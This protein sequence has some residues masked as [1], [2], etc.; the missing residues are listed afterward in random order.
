MILH[1]KFQYF[2]SIGTPPTHICI[3]Y[4][5]IL[6][7]LISIIILVTI[8]SSI[9]AEESRICIESKEIKH[10]STSTHNCDAHKKTIQTIEYSLIQINQHQDHSS[11][12]TCNDIPLPKFEYSNYHFYDYTINPRPII[13]LIS[14][15]TKTDTNYQKILIP[16]LDL[17]FKES[18]III[19]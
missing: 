9:F 4:V 1:S 6:K 12:H 5:M 15:N 2:N 18:T 19:V 13:S 8:F 7:K 10:S 14:L 11:C 16:I 3:F 17:S